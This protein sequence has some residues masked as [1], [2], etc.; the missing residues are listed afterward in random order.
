[1]NHNDDHDDHGFAHPASKKLLYTVFISLVGLTLL[2]VVANDWP[3]GSLDIWVAMAIAS[4]KA[5]LVMVFF[6]HMW[7]DKGFNVLAFLGSVLFLA[8][9]ISMT[10]MDTQNY[11]EDIESFP[12]QKRPGATSTIIP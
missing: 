8:L 4:V 3:L 2:T 11:R 10:L 6:M 7:W 1:M 12:L 5:I 9:F